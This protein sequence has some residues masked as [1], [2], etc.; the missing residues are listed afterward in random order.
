MLRVILHMVSAL[1][2][3]EFR[4][5]FNKDIQNYRLMQSEKTKKSQ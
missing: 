2:L 4:V 1:H 5:A 3:T